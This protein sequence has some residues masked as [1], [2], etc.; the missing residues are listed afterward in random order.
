MSRRSRLREAQSRR[1]E[2]QRRDNRAVAVTTQLAAFGVALVFLLVI[3]ALLRGPDAFAPL[4]RFAEPVVFG[5]TG[6]ELVGWSFVLW[7]A[8]VFWRRMR[9]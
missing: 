5:V 3:V 2:Q 6:L 9:K 7:L 4:C 1:A 8:V